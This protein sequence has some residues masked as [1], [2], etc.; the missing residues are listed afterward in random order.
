MLDYQ[1]V[2]LASPLPPR[3]PLN[4][5]DLRRFLEQVSCQRWKNLSGM[6]AAIAGRV[7]NH[8]FCGA[9]RKSLGVK[10]LRGRLTGRLF[11]LLL[12]F[13]HILPERHHTAKLAV[14]AV[15]PRRVGANGGLRP[16]K[17]GPNRDGLVFRD[18]DLHVQ[19]LAGSGWIVNLFCNYFANEQRLGRFGH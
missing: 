1:H 4:I 18:F 12:E 15:C 13:I 9:P 7:P 16:I 5:N 10:D 11:H 14:I 17:G 19:R 8:E 6:E 3:N 2:T